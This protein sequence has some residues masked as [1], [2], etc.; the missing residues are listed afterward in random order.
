VHLA[1]GLVQRRDL[2][3]VAVLLDFHGR[4]G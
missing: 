1:E 3:G 4:R 2:D